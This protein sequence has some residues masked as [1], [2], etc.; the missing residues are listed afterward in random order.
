MAHDLFHNPQSRTECSVSSLKTHRNAYIS[1]FYQPLLLWVAA[2]PSV[3]REDVVHIFRSTLT[4]RN[5]KGNHQPAH[6][7]YEA[8]SYFSLRYEG[9][10]R[11]CE[12]TMLSLSASSSSHAAHLGEVG[13]QC[14]KGI[15]LEI[16]YL[17][18]RMKKTSNSFPQ[19]GK[20]I[21]ELFSP[22]WALIQAFPC[23]VSA[24]SMF[25]SA[26]QCYAYTFCQLS[27]VLTVWRLTQDPT[28]HR[29]K[30]RKT[31]STPL[32]RHRV[33][34]L[35]AKDKDVVSSKNIHNI[36]S[37]IIWRVITGEGLFAWWR[38]N[39]KEFTLGTNFWY[40][41]ICFAYIVFCHTSNN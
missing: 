21:Y 4:Q 15:S 2:T 12:W 28:T 26:L 31:I 35:H 37:I 18:P 6:W 3:K 39:N 30:V 29:S 33:V 32:P 7:S 8:T 41:H 10:N 25:E 19:F 27:S 14:F 22:T 38:W 11:G 16:L 5:S 36:I 13:L 23:I 40:W 1:C 24:Q 17:S 34:A 9:N 20:F